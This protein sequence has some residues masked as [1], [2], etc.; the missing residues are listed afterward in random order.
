MVVFI[1]RA[2]NLPLR[3]GTDNTQ[4]GAAATPDTTGVNAR[5]KASIAIALASGVDVSISTFT[6]AS[7]AAALRAVGDADLQQRAD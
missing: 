3:A 5:F 7:K 6:K 1:T 2:L 4:I